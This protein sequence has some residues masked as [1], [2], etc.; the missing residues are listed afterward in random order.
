M[1]NAQSTLP[2]FE[3]NKKIQAARAFVTETLC[4]IYLT[5]KAG[6]GKTTFLKSL[7][8]FCPKQFIV[9]AP[10]W[11]CCRKCRGRDPAFLFSDSAGAISSRTK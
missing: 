3:G 7:Q 5:G 9:A 4:H 8:D 6:T 10:N 2:S 1:D 11:R